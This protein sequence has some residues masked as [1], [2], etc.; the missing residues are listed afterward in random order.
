MRKE[1]AVMRFTKMQGIGND[2]IY[3]NCFE[4]TVADPE[5]LSVKISDRHFG[6]GA[7][8]LVMIMPSEKADLRMRIFNA[9]GSEAKMCGNASRCIGKYAYERGLVHKDEITLETNSGIKILKLKI[10]NEAVTSVSVN[11]GKVS[12]EPR[13]I[14]AVS[15]E[16]LIN[17][18]LDVNG[19][20][21]RV[22]AVSVGNPHCVIFGG[23]PDDTDV[24]G[25]GKHIEFHQMF[26]ER[27]N[28]EFAQIL[29]D[30]KIKMR[31]WE[32]GSG[33]TLACGTG[34]CATAA[35]A[36]KNGYFSYGE[37]ITV[38]L[39]GGEL[40]ITV[41]EDGTVIKRGGAEFVFDGEI[42]V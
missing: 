1:A 14:P 25:I 30:H 13:D 12:F 3:V 40:Y 10:K 27:V 41:Y 23:D 15:E 9:D 39:R 22:T 24:E 35:A 26:P 11:M 31:V 20:E 33:E 32:R 34:A 16:P 19:T 38:I 7:D 18:L 28:V 5:R 42:A 21:Y 36:V 8:G 6:I 37:E 29:P 4:E 17:S 2:Y